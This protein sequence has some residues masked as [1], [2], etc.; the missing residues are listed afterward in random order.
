[1]RVRCSVGFCQI[2]LHIA[3]RDPHF[4]CHE[5]KSCCEVHTIAFFR[6]EQEIIKEA[7]G[8][9][10][11][12]GKC[13]AGSIVFHAAEICFQHFHPVI[14]VTGTVLYACKDLSDCIGYAAGTAVM[15]VNAAAVFLIIRKGISGL[16]L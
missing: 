8:I 14:P 6:C 4:I 16:I 9:G 5:N 7:S 13:T 11:R 12:V 10:Y 15:R 3:A 1:M 2:A